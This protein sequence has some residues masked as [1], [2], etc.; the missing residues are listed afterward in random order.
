MAARMKHLGAQGIIVD[1]RVR[2]LVA[3][4]Y[5]DLPIWSRGISI[6]GAGAETMFHARN[7]PVRIGETVVSPGDII[8]IDPLEKG[9][10]VIPQA[11][12][13]DVLRLLPELV[14]ADMRVIED[15]EAGGSVKEAFKAHRKAKL[16]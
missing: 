9:V 8:M 10:V 2:D 7:V 3:L 14:G 11:R 1:G 12:L 5:T 15:V 16:Q 13:E 6:I 4:A